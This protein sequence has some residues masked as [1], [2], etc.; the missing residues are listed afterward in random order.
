LRGLRHRA[1]AS[2]HRTIDRVAARRFALSA[3]ELRADIVRQAVDEAVERAVEET[4]YRGLREHQT[5]GPPERLTV[6]P[7]ATVND[8]LFNTVSGHVTVEDHAFFGHGVAILTGSHAVDTLGAARSTAIPTSGGDIVVGEGA[9][10]SSRAV[11]L[12][13]CR[14]G[15]HAVVAAGAVV[16]HDVPAGAVVA[17]I[18][19]RVLRHVALPDDPAGGAGL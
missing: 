9:W 14:I 16:T 4:R 5:F 2:L 1:G 6:A 19:A 12:G 18:P 10:V 8:A 3:D 7:S 13:P 11:V 17:G 15:R